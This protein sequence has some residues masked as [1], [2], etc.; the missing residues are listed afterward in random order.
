MKDLSKESKKF[1]HDMKM[2]L[3]II[4]LLSDELSHLSGDL[5]EWMY[6]HLLYVDQDN[7]LMC[8]ETQKLQTTLQGCIYGK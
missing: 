3:K 4:H 5:L 8:E 6:K 2:W 7:T 1:Q